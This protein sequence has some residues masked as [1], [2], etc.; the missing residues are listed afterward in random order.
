[1]D[2]FELHLNNFKSII[3]VLKE[4]LKF[5]SKIN[6]L[7]EQYD[8]KLIIAKANMVLGQ[9]K[10]SFMYL[11]HQTLKLLYTAL[12]RPHLEY[13]VSIWSPWYKTDIKI[14][15]RIQKRATKLVKSIRNK[16]YDERLKFLN[17]QNLEDR[18]LRGDLIQMYKLVNGVERVR[19]VKGLNYSNSLSLNLRRANNK[20]IVREI[21]KKA[22]CR[23]NFLTNRIV[24]KWN[25][26][27]DHAISVKTVNGFKACIDKEMFGMDRSKDCN[28]S[29]LG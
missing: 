13:A 19:L 18:R 3:N 1:M 20:R 16:T 6:P 4:D 24:S 5:V 21:N 2:E 10:N 8:S 28:G 12:V 11:D 7:S 29:V 27:S 22:S 26:L 15:E 17:L 23:F 25:E 9:I 14:L